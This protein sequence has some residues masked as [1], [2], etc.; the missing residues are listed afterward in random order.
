[1]MAAFSLVLVRNWRA[2]LTV[3][4]TFCVGTC[5]KPRATLPPMTYVQLM[6]LRASPGGDRLGCCFSEVCHAQSQSA[7]CRSEIP[8]AAALAG[9]GLLVFLF[10][11]RRID[12]G[13]L[14]P[15]NGPLAAVLFALQRP[16]V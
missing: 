13:C 2:I 12:A 1:M 11:N 9:A 4:P 7:F 6:V 8:G 3:L 10:A 16:V 14:E 15:G 5:V